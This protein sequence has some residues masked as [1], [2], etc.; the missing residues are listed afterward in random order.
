MFTNKV[1]KKTGIMLDIGCGKSSRPGFVGMDKRRLP[2]VDI[3]WDFEKFPW[4]PIKSN[5]VTTA[6]ASH[7]VEHVKPWLMIKWM[8]EV[9]RVLKPGGQLAITMPFGYSAG[10]LQDPTHC[11]MC[12]DTTWQ[13]FDPRC[14]LYNIYEPK[15]WTITHLTYQAN[16][17]ME[18]VL[19][20]TNLTHK[21]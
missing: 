21:Q 8:D 17:N 14:P 12:N 15:P 13:Y 11:N 20:K 5:S 7:V 9:W 6:V 19:T 3:V 16:G 18:V 1:K 10:F 4:K 2:E